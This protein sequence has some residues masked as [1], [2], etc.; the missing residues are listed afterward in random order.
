MPPDNLL[1]LLS[2][3]SSFALIALAS[4]QVGVLFN[5]I[6]LP[7]ITGYLLAGTLAGPFVLGFLP[8]GASTDLR[9]VD[10][11]SLS[12]IAFVAGSEL[13][14][15]D[16]RGRL[17]TILLSNAAIVV[18]AMLVIG[19]TLYVLTGI[20]PFTQ[21]FSPT[22]RHATALLGSTVLLALSPASTI[23]VIQ[24]VRARGPFT[25]T[26]LSITVVMD[27]V[28]IVLFAVST[29]FAGVLLS[30]AVL[31]SSFVLLLLLD[32]A[33]AL[34]IGAL[35]GLLLA[36]VLRLPLSQWLKIVLV[37]ALGTGL[38]TASFTLD[39]LKLGIHI[40][41][42]LT[43][44]VAG[45]FVTNFTDQ[46]KAFE[47]LLHDVGPLVYV[48]FFTLT[49]LAL[50]LD[51]LIS[52]GLIAL[53]LFAARAGGIFIGSYVGSSI[54][55]EPSTTRRLMW[56]GLITQA[57]IALGLA[58]EVAVQ[59]PDTLGDAFATLIIAVVVLNEIFGPLFLK[60]ALRQSGESNEPGTADPDVVRDAV[61]L[62]VE[63][64]SLALARELKSEGWQVV[65]A[66][67][68]RQ[69]VERL[70]AEDVDERYIDAVNA[71]QLGS[72]LTPATD[73]LVTMLDDDE[74]NLRAVEIASKHFG[75]K[76]LVVRVNDM[77]QAERFRALGA[78]VVDPSRAMI[79]LLD[80]CVRSPQTAAL[81][82]H[83]D[84]DYDIVQITVTDEAVH[85]RLIRDLRLPTDVLILEISRAGQTIVPSG[86]TPIQCKDEL[87]LV[88]KPESI[89]Q[90][91][92]KLGY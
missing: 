29:A 21:G 88:G 13:Y 66:D 53:V 46:R 16:L 51:I 48:A 2:T 42:L 17:R 36:F 20:I 70:V 63:P 43:A 44:L 9:I 87:T 24:E 10:D 52:S 11:L 8:E 58:R 15:K 78:I 25:K 91:T 12:V 82:M 81:M 26:V 56:A 65:L 54:A 38:F 1:A 76:R 90:V 84:R 39:E 50:K 35:L 40:E 37:L 27:V 92:L 77:A 55:G 67:T 19:G 18:A 6:G 23:A 89:Q 57:G 14:L 33:L 4:Y 34:G 75:I 31:D 79:S 7:K 74:A 32:L 30:D 49:G 22:A 73:A 59:F 60:Y 64:Q 47:E 68:A 83:Q 86:Y 71:K 85:G 62:G 3:F 69:H 41:P 61:I 28:I 5:K 80:Q 72:L 45:F